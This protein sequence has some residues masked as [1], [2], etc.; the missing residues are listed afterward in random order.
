MDLEQRQRLIVTAADDARL[1]AVLLEQCKDDITFWFNTFCY[2]FN[3][4]VDPGTMPFN[5]Y[6]FQEWMV[7]ECYRA[8]DEQED[9]LIEKSRDMGASWVI[10]LMFQYCWLFRPGWH[11]LIGSYREEEVDKRGDM[12]TIFEK[13]RFNL[14]WLPHWMKPEGYNSKAHDSHLKLMN[15]ANGNTIVGKS[16]TANFARSGRYRAIFLDEFAFWPFADLVMASTSQ[17]TNCRLVTSTPF[18]AANTFA[19]LAQDADEIALPDELK[20][21]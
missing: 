7:K 2:T 12:S 6:P 13:I 11:F 21:A 17:S 3:P 16:A 10:A 5:L 1:Q 18:G 19:R 9:L 20:A 8:I 4:R 15:P 14:E